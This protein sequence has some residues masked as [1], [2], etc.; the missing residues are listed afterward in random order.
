MACYRDEWPCIIIT[1]SSLRGVPHFLLQ[2]AQA[3]LGGG[4]ACQQ[5]HVVWYDSS[6]YTSLAAKF[7]GVPWDVSIHDWSV[8]HSIVK[9]A[10]V[11]VYMTDSTCV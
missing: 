1:P 10:G 4:Y 7:R 2:S 3:S 9:H 8:S 5:M 11:L 6:K